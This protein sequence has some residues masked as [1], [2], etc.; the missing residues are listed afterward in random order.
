MDALQ[1]KKTPMDIN[2]LNY[3]TY[4]GLSNKTKFAINIYKNYKHASTL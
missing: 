2:Y 4:N 3:F 1:M